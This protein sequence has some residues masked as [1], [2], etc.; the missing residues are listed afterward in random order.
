MDI[1]EIKVKAKFIVGLTQG[2]MALEGQ[3]LNSDQLKELE[4]DC[5]KSLLMRN[6]ELERY[7]EVALETAYRLRAYAKRRGEF[8]ELARELIDC[9]EEL[10][11]AIQYEK[12]KD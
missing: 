11:D 1:E 10:E 7:K 4:A 2:T 5:I 12:Q 9:A 8:D 3:G 6:S